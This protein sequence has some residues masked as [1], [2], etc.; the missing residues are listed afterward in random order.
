M[1]LYSTG[2]IVI[3]AA[4]AALLANIQRGEGFN[5][6]NPYLFWGAQMIFIILFVSATLYT[7]LHWEQVGE[8]TKSRFFISIII[9]VFMY[10]LAYIDS[11]YAFLLIFVCG[12]AEGFF[13]RKRAGF[14]M[15]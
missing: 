13:T 12:V 3:I 5:Q 2:M 9:C 7:M 11:I 1:R 14:I 4:V 10:A 6:T 8:L 15:T